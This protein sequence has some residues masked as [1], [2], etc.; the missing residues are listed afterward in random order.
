MFD[1]LTNRFDYLCLCLKFI[2]VVAH[3]KMITFSYYSLTLLYLVCKRLD[4]RRI[5]ISATFV[6][7][8]SMIKLS[9]VNNFSTE[10]TMLVLEITTAKNNDSVALTLID[11]IDL[12]DELIIVFLTSKAK[13]FCD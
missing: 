13:G 7:D 5:M 2:T 10:A 4:Q 3:R 12:I 9:T 8:F 1:L 6:E 11:L